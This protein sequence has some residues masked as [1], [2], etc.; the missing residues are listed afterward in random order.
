QTR[1]GRLLVPIWKAPFATFAIY[2]DDHGQTWHRGQTV[3]GTHGGDECQVVELA[4]GRILMDIR[5]ETGPSRWLAESE[6]G[7]NTWGAPRIGTT[8]TPVACAI[9]RLTLAAA[10]EERNR[11]LWTGPAGAERRRLMI[12]TSY[13]EGKT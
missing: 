4:D 7:G 10:G 9:E 5:Q 11:L 8:V 2:S 13:D 1:K 3:P 6:D 12:R